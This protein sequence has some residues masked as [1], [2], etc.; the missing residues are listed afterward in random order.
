MISADLTQAGFP[1]EGTVFPVSSHRLRVLEGAHPW[2]V[3]NEA[4]IA[5]NWAREIA[6][7]PRLF[8][9][10]MV[11]QRRLSYADGH[12]EG[13]AHMVPYAAFLHWR[14]LGRMA[15]GHH[16]FSMPLILS[17]YG[18]LIAIRMADT[19]ANPGRVYSPAGSLD[20]SDV[21]DGLCRLEDNMRRETLEETGLALE[22]MDADP[23]CR[24]LHVANSVAVF[25]VF[26]SPV[27]AAEIRA[28]VMRH[29]AD[30]PDPEIS[31]LVAIRSADPAAHDYSAF[32]LPVLD[33]VFN[34]GM[35]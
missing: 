30:D 6:A 35:K 26:R 2:A 25:R 3:E 10:Q 12:I 8:N 17:A 16:L 23:V 11:F 21:V 31:D 18:A 13:E 22:M 24:G 34:K 29:M 14:R 32:M 1:A 19:T 15:G 7:N 9:G 28:Q 5:E 20:T 4:D 33:W 27:D